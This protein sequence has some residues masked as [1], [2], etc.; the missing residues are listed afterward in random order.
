MKILVVYYS[1]TG[2]TKKTAINISKK[3]GADLDEVS[4]KTDRSGPLGYMLAGKDAMKGHLTQ[5]SF[6]HEPKDYDMIIIGGPV[7]AWTVTPA[8]RTYIDKNSDA[9]KVKKVAFFATQGS[10][11]AEKK[12]EVMEKMLGMKPSATLI[13]NGK[14]FR[15]DSFESMIEKFVSSLK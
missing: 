5:I 6:G 9:L 10:S 3:L 13:I 2:L 15:N 7:W 12:F 1:R 11:G 14:D 4:D 8:I